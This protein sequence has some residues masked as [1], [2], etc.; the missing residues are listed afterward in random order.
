MTKAERLEAEIKRTELMKELTGS[1]RYTE[2]YA[3]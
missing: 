1:I 2:P 3:A